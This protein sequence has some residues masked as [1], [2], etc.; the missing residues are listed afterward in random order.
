MENIKNILP[1]ILCVVGPTASGKTAYAIELARENKY[2][3]TRC[4]FINI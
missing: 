4:R 3:A 2:L 1:K